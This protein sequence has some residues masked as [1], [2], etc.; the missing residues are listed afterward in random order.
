MGLWRLPVEKWQHMPRWVRALLILAAISFLAWQQR[1]NLLRAAG[2]LLVRED[3]VHHADAVFVLGGSAMDRGSEAARLYAMGVSGRFVFTGAPVSPDLQALGI[4]STEAAC[5][6]HIAVQQGLPAALAQALNKGTSTEEEAEALLPVAL[7][8]GAD[9]VMV[10]STPF[11]LRRVRFVFQDRFR[12]A[13][14]TVL[15]HG[16]PSTLFDERYWWRK[17]EGLLMCANEYI[18]LVYYHLKY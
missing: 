8:M 3:P 17:E 10:V 1:F 18:K 9:T 13:G 6:R 7:A 15:L 2:D 5:T 4:D 11:H 12:Q 14:I 16:A